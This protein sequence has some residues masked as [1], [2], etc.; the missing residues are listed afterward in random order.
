MKNTNQTCLAINREISQIIIGGIEEIV[1]LDD[2]QK[3]LENN[4][5]P[6]KINTKNNIVIEQSISLKQL[7]NI[8]KN[9]V[10]KYGETGCR[11]AAYHFGRSFFSGFYR[12]YGD[13][14]GLNTLDYRMLPVK[15]RIYTGL[16]KI[17]QWLSTTT[18]LEIKINDDDQRW[19]WVNLSEQNNCECRLTITDFSIG[20]LQGFLSWASG[21]KSYPIKSNSQ[22]MTHQVIEIEKKAII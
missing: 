12:E 9:L 18:E 16:E 13:Q 15:K 14:T 10:E 19:Y 5:I 11:G 4:Q 1:G 8:E 22:D 17:S 20:M 21:G 6:F 3:I 2:L 7:N